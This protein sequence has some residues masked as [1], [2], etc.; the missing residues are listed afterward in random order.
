MKLSRLEANKVVRRVLNRHYVDLGELNFSCS[1]SEVRFLGYVRKISGY[2]LSYRQMD[3]LIRDL[4]DGLPGYQL[5]G[6][7]TNWNF[8]NSYC[9]ALFDP[10]T[11]ETDDIDEVEEVEP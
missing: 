8:S 5:K 7:T 6:E 4:S 9:E 3:H 2:E 10:N 11:V 1:A